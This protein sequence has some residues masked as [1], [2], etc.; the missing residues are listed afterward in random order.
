MIIIDTHTHIYDP[1]FDNDI[2]EVINRSKQAGVTQLLLP[3]VD[4]ASIEPL[5]KLADR[6]SNYC[7]PMMGLHPTS[8]SVGWQKELDIIKQQFA[9][10]SYV[11]VGEIGIDLHWDTSF[12]DAQKEAFEEQLRWS[13]QYNLPVS[14][15]SRDAVTECIQCINNVG[16]DKL[17]GT[18][19]SFGGTQE[20]LLQ[21]ISLTN[22]YVG[23][24]GTVT[25]KNSALPT[26]IQQIG[27]A[28]ILLETDAPYLPPIPFRGKR[29]EPAYLSYVVDK[30]AELFG[31]TPREVAQTTSNNAKRLFRI[32]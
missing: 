27:I 7:L 28:R 5:H 29:N 6:Y 25:Y 17:Y 11:A 19:H 23:I 14:I 2:E 9:T 32:S 13:I 10:R 26:F 21:L 16:A 22:F 1:R 18:F 8:V 4:R 12:V 3:N 15:H 30:L 31:I 24:N 20:E